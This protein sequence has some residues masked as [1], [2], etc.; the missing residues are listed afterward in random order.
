MQKRSGGCAQAGAAGAGRRAAVG[1]GGIS[2]GRTASGTGRDG[3]TLAVRA[4]FRL[5]PAC[6]SEAV[7]ISNGFK[8][9]SAG[10][11][12][13]N[14]GSRA[15]NR[16]LRPLIGCGCR[17]ATDVSELRS[18]LWVGIG[19]HSKSYE[20]AFDPARAAIPGDEDL[21]HPSDFLCAPCHLAAR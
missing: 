15:T 18:G 19:G 20:N 10:A 17:A 4:R 3:R 9:V 1:A 11:S 12:D 7:T 16:P 8:W 6:A 14:K 5:L 21:L 2:H 13:Q